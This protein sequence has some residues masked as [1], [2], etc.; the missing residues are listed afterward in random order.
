[1]PSDRTLI[2]R[3]ARYKNWRHLNLTRSFVAP[4]LKANSTTEK[5]DYAGLQAKVRKLQFEVDNNKTRRQ[6]PFI[7]SSPVPQKHNAELQGLRN[8]RDEF[9]RERDLAGHERDLAR[10]G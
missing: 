8:K 5:K 7:T 9:A 4:A 10:Q 1:M 2:W 3:K 6:T